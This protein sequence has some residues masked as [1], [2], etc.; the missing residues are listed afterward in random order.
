MT[1]KVSRKDVQEYYG[2]VLKTKDDLKTS[3]CCGAES[4]APYIRDILNRIAPEIL[5]KCEEMGAALAAGVAFGV[6]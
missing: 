3:A 4:M 2:R 5:E 6:F 1:D